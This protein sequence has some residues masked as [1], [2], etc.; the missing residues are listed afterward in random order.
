MILS[1]FIAKG[2]TKKVLH[3]RMML[4][5]KKRSLIRAPF[6]QGLAMNSANSL[7]KLFQFLETTYNTYANVETIYVRIKYF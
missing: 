3:F 5:H 4:D 2:I 6:K 1:W 7:L